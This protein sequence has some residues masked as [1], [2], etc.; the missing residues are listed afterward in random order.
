MSRAL[1]VPYVLYEADNQGSVHR[2]WNVG[3]EVQISMDL[4]LAYLP[5]IIM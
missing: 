2:H 4:L 1:K 5:G 3:L